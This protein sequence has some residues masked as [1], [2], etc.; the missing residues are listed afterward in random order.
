LA[1][2]AT[3]ALWEPLGRATLWCVRGVLGLVFSDVTYRPAE[4]AV[5]ARGFVV[6]VAPSCSGYEG[7]GLIWA[8]LGVYLWF[9]RRELRFPQAFWLVPVGTVVM[10][11]A[12]V[13]RIV[14][15]VA[16]GATL[17]PEV[18]L[19]GFHSQ[20]GWLAFNAVALGLVLLSRRAQLFAAP[21]SDIESAV[22]H[23]PTAFEGPSPSAA[24]LAPLLGLV[25]A[26]M[27]TTALS[28]PSGFD[29][30]Y[31]ARVLVTAGLLWMFRDGHAELWGETNRR[32]WWSWTAV[33]IGL[34]VFVLWMALEPA[35]EP[36][37]GSS[38]SDGL[39]RLPR[40]L[41]ACWLAFRVLGSVVTVPL[42]EELAF[43]GYLTRRLIRAD[44]SEVEPGRLTW[45]SL[46]ISSLVFGILHGR[47][48]AGTIAGVLYALA[49]HRRGRLSDAVLAHALTNALIAAY[50]LATGSWSLWL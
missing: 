40:G 41:A 48:L 7:V 32:A 9:F 24:Y 45:P 10:W 6:E 26:V 12:N 35:A 36:G 14:A 19:G 17:S 3:G 39:S 50:V 33:A 20:A 15:L 28:P 43:R 47:W 31:P 38:I 30:F 1:G 37:A 49:Y 13:A 25:A 22:E 5:G 21:E 42:A 16:L 46:L 18:A 4:A 27:V 8:F 2:R 29:A 44:F 34:A 23:S 11:C